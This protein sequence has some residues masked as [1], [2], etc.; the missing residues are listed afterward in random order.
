MNNQTPKAGYYMAQEL[1]PYR[2]EDTAYLEKIR[3]KNSENNDIN[4]ECNKYFYKC[5]VSELCWIKGLR[6]ESFVFEEYIYSLLR[7][8][9]H[10][11]YIIRRSRVLK[12]SSWSSNAYI[13][14][15]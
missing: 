15:R 8:E 10:T 9:I 4:R 14:L 12:S 5:L 3:E 1:Q 7:K 11:E 2:P 13:S 6:G